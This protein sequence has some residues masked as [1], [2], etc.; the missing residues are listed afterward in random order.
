MQQKMQIDRLRNLGTPFMT[1]CCS[2]DKYST[3][4]ETK[5][6]YIQQFLSHHALSK[7]NVASDLWKTSNSL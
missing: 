2:Y 3:Y 5:Y 1:S 4:I 6:L 7:L